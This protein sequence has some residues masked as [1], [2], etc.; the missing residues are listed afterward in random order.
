MA[1][2]ILQQAVLNC[3]HSGIDARV[4]QL[5]G[6]NAGNSVI[7]VLANVDLVDGS[8]LPAIASND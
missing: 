1:L 2:E 7:I 5:Y 6:T 3:Q 8:L 4:S